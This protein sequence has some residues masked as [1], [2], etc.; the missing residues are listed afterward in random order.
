MLTLTRPQLWRAQ[1]NATKNI[2]RNTFSTNL[3]RSPMQKCWKMASQSRFAWR[4]LLPQKTVSFDWPQNLNVST[5]RKK[6]IKA[7]RNIHSANFGSI[8]MQKC[9]KMASQWTFL[10]NPDFT[11]KTS[12][13]LITKPYTPKCPWPKIF[14]IDVLSYRQEKM[15]ICDHSRE[16]T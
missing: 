16:R 4:S 11:H 5:K 15:T 9:W 1:S 12:A 8:P 14:F 3:S 13:V 2:P 7:S 10:W 6:K